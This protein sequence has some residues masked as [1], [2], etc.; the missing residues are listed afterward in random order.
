VFKDKDNLLKKNEKLIEQQKIIEEK[1]AEKKAS[2][3]N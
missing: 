1:E 2:S 3:K